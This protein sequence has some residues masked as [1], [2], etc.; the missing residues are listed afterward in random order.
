MILLDTT[1]LVYAVGG[2]H[3]LRES[4]ANLVAAIGA[5][6]LSA[7]TT[8]EVLQEF[9]H[10][11]ARRRGRQD[12]ADLAEHYAALLSPLGEVGNGD[13]ADGLGLYRS[14]DELGCFDA[15][16]AAVVLNRDHITALVS[17][18]RAFGKV[19]GLRQIDPA[20]VEAWTDD[21]TR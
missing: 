12:A 20:Q 21:V 10:V 7:T 13:L 19:E 5:G 14:H 18:D 3:P 16:L 17:A 8:V 11:R 4:C 6:S 2:D 9:A 15:V 1:V